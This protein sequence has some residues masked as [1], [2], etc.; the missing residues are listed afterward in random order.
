V[1]ICGNRPAGMTSV[2]KVTKP[3]QASTSNLSSGRLCGG[4]AC[5]AELVCVVMLYSLS[6]LGGGQL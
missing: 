1:L 5:D 4:A 3:A 6:K 2:I